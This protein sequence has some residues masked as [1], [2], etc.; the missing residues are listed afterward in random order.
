MMGHLYKEAL[1]HLPKAAIGVI[2]TN[3][4]LDT[5]IYEP[6]HLTN[7]KQ[8]INR[9]PREL[10]KILYYI[11]SWDVVEMLLAS[12]RKSQILYY[13]DDATRI[14]YVYALINIK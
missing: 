5:I 6:C 7:L 3:N 14:H 1:N 10:L 2:F 9:A 4:N 11:V 12:D 8:I 13:I